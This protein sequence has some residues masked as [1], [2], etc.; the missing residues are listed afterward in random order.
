MEE[1]V[2]TGLQ[3]FVIIGKTK[4]REKFTA[5][6]IE[7]GA[8]SIDTIYG[9]GSVGKSILAQAFGLDGENK[10][11]IISCLLPTENAQRVIDVLYNEF[12]FN[13]AN[14]GIAFSVPIQKLL[15]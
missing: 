1:K 14:T 11:V 13:K 5:M 9:R 8:H 4:L 15:F 10:K 7:N 3:Y 12:H 2:T 6:L